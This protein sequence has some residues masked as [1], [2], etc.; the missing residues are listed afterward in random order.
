MD[1]KIHS[2]D[3]NGIDSN[4]DSNVTCINSSTDRQ[5]WVLGCVDTYS[6]VRENTTTHLL[7]K[8]CDSTALEKEAMMCK[9]KFFKQCPTD[10]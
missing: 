9:S 7:R 1:L 10:G 6:C 3:I 5:G 8:S 4:V 2:I